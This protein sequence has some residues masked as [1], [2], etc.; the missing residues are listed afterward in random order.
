LPA[1]SGG[2]QVNEITCDSDSPA[3]SPGMTVQDY[4]ASAVDGSEFAFLGI[5][6]ERP[7]FPR[8][9]NPGGENGHSTP[10]G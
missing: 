2:E 4:A 9:A 6:P 3:R 7:L 5:Q 8:R 10:N 1:I